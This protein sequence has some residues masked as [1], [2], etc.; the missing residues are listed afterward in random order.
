[1]AATIEGL[2]GEISGVEHPIE[3]LQLLKTALLSLPVNALRDA[4]SGQR[5]NVIFALLSS[6]CRSV[7][8]SHIL[9]VLTNERVTIA[10]SVGSW[11]SLQANASPKSPV[12]VEIQYTWELRGVNE[13]WTRNNANAEWL[14]HELFTILELKICLRAG[15][16]LSCAWTSL[17][18]F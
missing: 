2:L 6:D 12:S 11:C 7:F 9:T 4:L 17:N 14:Q 18:V 16:R 15:S 3:E 8:I 10:E 5:F 13:Q 1:M